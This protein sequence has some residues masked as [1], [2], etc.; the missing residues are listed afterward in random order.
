MES[1]NLEPKPSLTK[2]T[3]FNVPPTA[4]A[5]TSTNVTPPPTTVA[6]TQLTFNSRQFWPDI[7]KTPSNPWTFTCK[8]IIDKLNTINEKQNIPIPET[9]RI[10]EKCLLYFYTLKKKLNLFDHTYTASSI[11]FFRL[12]YVQGLPSNLL[13]CIHISQAILVTACKSMENNRPLETYVKATCEFLFQIMPNLKQKYNMDKLKWE[14]RD[15]LI[16]NEKRIL[17]IFGFDLNIDNPKEIIED[18]FSGFYRY[19]RDYDLPQDFMKIFPKILQ[20]ARN[21]IIQAVTQPISLLCDG[22]TFIVLSL[23]YCGLQYKEKVDQNFIYPKNF[24]QTRLGVLIDSEKFQNYFT[25]YRILEE[26]F[27][28]LKSNKGNKLNID[29]EK[30]DT[31]IDEKRDDKENEVTTEME[32][33]QNKSVETEFDI[34]DYENVR[35]GE[36]TKELLDYLDNRVNELKEKTISESKKRSAGEQINKEALTPKKAKI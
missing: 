36:V 1:K 4:V 22:N 18:L 6:K 9:K 10:M 8:E 16:E 27:F 14:V 29:K 5:S 15:K 21:F 32:N 17:C 24:F 7:I 30:I 2:T 20:E 35:S 23:L 31:I 26:N 33:I 34:H 25:D 12:W 3:S 13:T 28:E 19:N 11:L